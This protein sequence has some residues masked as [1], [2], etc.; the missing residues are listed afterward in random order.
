MDVKVLKVYKDQKDHKECKDPQE[1]KGPPG[2]LVNPVTPVL[3]DLRVQK[4]KW[5]PKETRESLDREEFHLIRTGRN[6]RGKPSVT[7]GTTGL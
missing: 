7:I 5:D 3:R 6:V 1:N 4:D 2:L